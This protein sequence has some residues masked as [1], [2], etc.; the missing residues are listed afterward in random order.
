[1]Y[2]S[3]DLGKWLPD[4]S[5]VY[6]GRSDNQVKVNGYRVELGEIESVLVNFA[7]VNNAAVL[8]RPDATGELRLIGIHHSRKRI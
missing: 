2:R 1:M 8:A 5:L 6:K 3:G 4:G 7:S